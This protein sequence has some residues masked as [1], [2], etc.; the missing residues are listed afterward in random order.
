MSRILIK[1]GHIVTADNADRCF[2][3]GYV[4]IKND[5]I[6]DV[7]PWPPKH[8]SLV[9]ADF[10]EV[11]DA[12]DRIVMPGFINAHMHSN[13]SFEQ[14]AYDN[15]PLELWL[16]RAYPPSGVPALGPE[17]NY[18]RSMIVAIQSL[19][20]GV[21]TIQDDVINSYAKEDFVDAA[22]EGAVRAY[23]DAGLRSVVTV[24]FINTNFADGRPFMRDILPADKLAHVDASPAPDYR[25]QIAQFNDLYAKWQGYK[26]RTNIILGPMS[27]QRITT[28]F[29]EEIND[30]SR[31]RG[32]AVHCHVDETRNQAV[33]GRLFYGS[34]MI[35]HLATIGALSPR[36]TINHGIWVTDRDIELLAEHGCSVTH[37]PLSN[38]KLGS[39][40]C[41]VRKML[42][43][44]VNVAIGTDG[45]S[46][47]DTGD[48]IEAIRAASLL[49]RLEGKHH[50]EWITALDVFNMVLQGGA[51]STLM[52]TE[53]GSIEAGKKADIIL[54]D[55]NDWGFIPLAD[56][57]R[58]LAFSVNSGAVRTTIVDGQVVM[59]DRE[60]CH[61]DENALRIQV[62]ALAERYRTE[63]W[64]AMQQG[65]ESILPYLEEMLR[66]SA[67]YPMPEFAAERNAYLKRPA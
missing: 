64:P 59:R 25:A 66:R 56:P 30:I 61:I 23:A 22:V 11:I 49:H 41:P 44:G 32:I 18:L 10:D 12:T 6:I 36:L 47:S 20:S 62:S 63:Y 39:G 38:M 31:S 57:V 37:N 65:A 35:E 29:W 2:A 67:M 53:I 42:R 16:A 4:V 40:V 17:E 58:Q 45:T 21:T 15:L 48:M 9:E 33:T 51:R 7:G 43:A 28:P 52:Q 27:P 34:S 46:T 5:R 14:G 55:R 8:D 13:E 60:L 3:P 50:D 24:S 54:L 26:G 1:N 19:R